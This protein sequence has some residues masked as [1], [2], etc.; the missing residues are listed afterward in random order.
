MNAV[1]PLLEMRGICKRFPGVTALDA[2]DLSIHAHEVQALMGDHARDREGGVR[3]VR[4][5][6]RQ[7]S[8][9]RSPC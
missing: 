1:A 7:V 5:R 3:E 9:G 6:G 4:V 8:A 2:V